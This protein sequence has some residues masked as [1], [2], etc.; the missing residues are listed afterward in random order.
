M[1]N[2]IHSLLL[3]ELDSE[4]IEHNKVPALN[5]KMIYKKLKSSSIIYENKLNL[6][7]KQFNKEKKFSFLD[8]EI[9]DEKEN[10]QNKENINSNLKNY[11]SIFT[12]QLLFQHKH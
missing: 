12:E 8:P 11:E 3:N 2:D 6:K 7:L 1:G 10:N 5:S 4:N 9:I